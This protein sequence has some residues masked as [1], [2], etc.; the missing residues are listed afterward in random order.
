MNWHRTLQLALFDIRWAVL[1][2]KGLM[3]ILPYFLFWYLVLKQFYEGAAYT[4]Q[5]NGVLM[6]TSIGF[7]METLNHLFIELPPSMSAFFIGAIYTTPF[8][9]LLAAN[10]LFA[11]DLGS[12]YFRF[13]ITRCHRLEIFLA[14]CLAV[15]LIILI[16]TIISG[17]AAALI[18]TFIEGYAVKVTIP[19]L[20]RIIGMLMFYSMP[21]IAIMAIVSA[22]LNSPIGVILLASVGYTVL[23]ICIY[24][25]EAALDDPLIFFYLL[26]SGIRKDLISPD[27]TD[28]LVALASTPAYTLIFAWLAWTL[29][30]RRNF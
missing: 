16:C 1:R 30:K 6:L 27:N 5:T 15:V 28:V 12:G 20:L 9:I 14:R 2:R 19:Y 29:F 4:I 22:A 8:F 26:P 24:I 11:S 18:A 3:Y 17:V 23:L 25:A 10:D 7:D 21:F 13:L